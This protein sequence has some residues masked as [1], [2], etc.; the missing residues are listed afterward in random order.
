GKTKQQ[1][2]P[3]SLVAVEQR[4]TVDLDLDDIRDKLNGVVDGVEVDQAG[5]PYVVDL[6]IGATEI[7]AETMTRLTQLGVYEA[8]VTAGA[9]RDRVDRTEPAGAA[10]IHLGKNR[11]TVQNQRQAAL[12]NGRTWAEVDIA[13]AARWVQGP[14][15]Y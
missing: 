15:F 13:D 12:D 4:I 5:R 3:R 10:L 1:F 7:S 8:M 2:G 14:Y 6:E 11:A 9:L